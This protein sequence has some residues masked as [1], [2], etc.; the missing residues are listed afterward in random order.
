[1]CFNREPG[2]FA[3]GV[4]K[5]FSFRVDWHQDDR[6]NPLVRQYQAALDSVLASHPE[7]SDCAVHCVQ[8]G[9]RFLT[10]PRN[11]C[12]LDLRCPFGCQRH[13]RRQCSNQRSTAYYRTAAGIAKKKRLNARRCRPPQPIGAEEVASPVSAPSQPLPAAK[14]TAEPFS[15]TPSLP[16]ELALSGVVLDE[17]HVTGSPLLPYVR[18]LISLI[19]GV[20]F[21]LQDLVALLCRSLRQHSFARRGRA[22]YVV[23]YLQQHPP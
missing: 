13:H 17:T 9:I 14:P 1:L 8:C 4:E 18:M 3:I 11:A 19:E 10:H 23:A 7:L 6:V 22:D 12:R 16:I 5:F 2:F 21:R 15:A 20:A